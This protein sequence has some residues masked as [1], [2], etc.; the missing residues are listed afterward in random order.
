[1][2][3]VCGDE[4]ICRSI[5]TT[6]TTIIDSAGESNSTVRNVVLRTT[7]PTLHS[8]DLCEYFADQD[9]F[10]TLKLRNRGIT[11]VMKVF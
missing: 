2:L 1:M 7:E 6:M 8:F 11:V 4:I 5:E 3:C 10:E 9:E